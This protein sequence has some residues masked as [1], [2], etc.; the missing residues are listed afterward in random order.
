MKSLDSS[1]VRKERLIDKNKIT[2]N[3]ADKND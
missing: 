1:V 3:E 2:I